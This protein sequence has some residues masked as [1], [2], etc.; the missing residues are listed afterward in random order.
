MSSNEKI[1]DRKLFAVYGFV[2][3]FTAEPTSFGSGVLH[4][5]AE[6]SLGDSLKAAWSHRQDIAT[7]RVLKY[8]GLG[9]EQNQGRPSR[10]AVLLLTPALPEAP[11]PDRSQGD[12]AGADAPAAGITAS[13]GALHR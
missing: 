4:H 7:F 6:E 1:K 3:V 2:S 11:G 10:P 5:Q 9:K 13:G 8:F 12:S